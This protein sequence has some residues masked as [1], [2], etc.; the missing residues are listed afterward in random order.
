MVS[1]CGANEDEPC[2]SSSLVSGGTFRLGAS[3]EVVAS[4][5]DYR[6]DTYEVTVGRFR[7]FKA[8]WDEGSRPSEGD[9][10]HAHLRGGTGLV[11]PAELAE[12]GWLAAWEDFV[13]TGD[14][15][16]L[17]DGDPQATWTD[18]EDDNENLPINYVN[19]Y[20][21][22]AFCTWDQG[23]LPSEAEWEYAAAGGPEPDGERN[24]PWGSTEPDC[25]Y[26]NYDGCDDGLSIAGSRSPQGDGR[27]GHSDLAGSVYEWVFDFQAEGFISPC[28]N[29]GNTVESAQRVIRGGYWDLAA[30]DITASSRSNSNPLNRSHAVGVRC[31][32]LP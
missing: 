16:R 27:F 6:L 15:A 7:R 4:I 9:G 13:D 19:W 31:A 8:A 30:K 14:A 1:S 26:A 2:C 21:A 22:V 10:K 11:G 24:Y 12:S 17:G 3:D 29:C 25:A 18:E 32:R 28:D 20:E 5:S 23:F